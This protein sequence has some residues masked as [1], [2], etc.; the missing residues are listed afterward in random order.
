MSNKESTD[1]CNI[2]FSF[3]KIT[4][5]ALI[6]IS[7]LSLLFLII[8]LLYRSFK[9]DVANLPPSSGT[10]GLNS[11]GI[12]G[13][14]FIIIHSGKFSRFKLP[15][16]NDSTTCN[17]FKASVLRC[18]D[19]SLL[20]LSL[21]SY[22]SPSKSILDNNSIRHSAPILAINFSGSLSSKYMFSGGKESKTFKY[23]SSVRKS[24][25]FN[26]SPSIFLALPGWITTYLS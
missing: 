14:A 5:G 22:E 23:S 25:L 24:I 12:T 13:I 18:F 20:A 6:S 7:L 10:K 21:S 11:G 19:V 15:S 1:S 17:L 26:G 2:L 3:L 9:S 8:T 16:L 4:S